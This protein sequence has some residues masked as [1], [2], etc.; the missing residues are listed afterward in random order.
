M[1]VYLAVASR[2]D[3]KTGYADRPV[4]DDVVTRILDAGRLAGSASNRQP[5]RFVR[6][7]SDDARERVAELVYSPSYVLEAPLVVVLVATSGRSAGLDHGR[8]AQ[9]MLVTAAGEALAS[10]V[11]QF[12]DRDAAHEALG[13]GPDEQTALVTTFGYPRRPRDPHARDAAEWS[14]RADRR[15]L[16]ELVTRI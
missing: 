9:N 6:V 3:H 16:D 1:D 15:P 8:A 11:T 13:L 7:E 2:R 5:W 14:R 10:S 12:R 4:P